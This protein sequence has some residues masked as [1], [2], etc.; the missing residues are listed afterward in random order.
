M[1]FIIKIA[2]K[3]NPF[4][5]DKLVQPKT[6]ICP[7]FLTRWAGVRKPP[8]RLDVVSYP[9]GGVYSYNY[10]C[11]KNKYLGEIKVGG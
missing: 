2:N 10:Y 4:I 5:L 1:K 8:A 7:S 11:I 3:L 9:L 6:P